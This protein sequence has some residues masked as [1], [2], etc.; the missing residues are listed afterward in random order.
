MLLSRIDAERM[1]KLLRWVNFERRLPPQMHFCMPIYILPRA[2]TDFA[3]GIQSHQTNIIFAF[4]KFC[5]GLVWIML[6]AMIF[7]I[8]KHMEKLVKYYR[9]PRV[10]IDGVKK[11]V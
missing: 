9:F 7:C 10:K 1:E 5:F 11:I 6:I 2:F 4:T 8:K 3:P